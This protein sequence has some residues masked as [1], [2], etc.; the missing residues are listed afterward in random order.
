MSPAFQSWRSVALVMQS[1]NHASAGR[2]YKSAALVCAPQPINRAAE[3]GKFTWHANCLCNKKAKTFGGH[4]KIFHLLVLQTN[5]IN[6]VHYLQLSYIVYLFIDPIF[7]N[8]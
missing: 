1:I 6:L 8:L 4:C 7:G 2:C 3:E 5:N